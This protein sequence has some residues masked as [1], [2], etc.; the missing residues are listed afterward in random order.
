LKVYPPSVTGT[1]TAASGAALYARLSTSFGTLMT[2][3]YCSGSDCQ[4]FAVIV[5]E[6]GSKFLEA[7]DSTSMADM[8]K[9]FNNEG[10]AA[11]GRHLAITSWFYWCWN[12]NSGDTG[13]LVDD[14]WVKV[15]WK[16]IEYL[17]TAGLTSGL[18]VSP[19][20]PPPPPSPPAPPPGPPPPPAA[21]QV[22]VEVASPWLYGAGF[23]T[24]LNVK[25]QTVSSVAVPWTLTLGNVGYSSVVSSWGAW[26]GVVI[27]STALQG[28]ATLA[29]QAIS[30][31]SF[32]STGAQVGGGADLAPKT[33]TLN[34]MPC[35]LRV[36]PGGAQPATSPASSP[37]SASPP[38]PRS[39]PPPTPVPP[40]RS[41]PPS[42]LPP[43][44]P[45]PPR[46][47]PL[48]RPPPPRHPPPKRSPPPRPPGLKR[49][50]PP[51]RKPP[52]SKRPKKSVG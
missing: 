34:G 12:P 2:A 18:A 22:S 49:S 41:P 36:P 24:T 40:K 17:R 14:E 3:G 4:R 10:A 30:A 5:G 1:A 33:A 29:W 32:V 19:M 8:V 50:P 35:S 16:K 9:Y 42:S 28:S 15:Q 25:L 51:S 52:P 45:P 21:S 27:T 23:T 44:R 7:T 39:P 47:L 31:G 20:S 38:P 6:F 43:K 46:S 48:K 26:G 37:K 11:D 13:G